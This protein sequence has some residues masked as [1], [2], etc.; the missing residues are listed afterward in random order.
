MHMHHGNRAETATLD[1]QAAAAAA[2]VDRL[3]DQYEELKRQAAEN[4]AE[5]SGWSNVFGLGIDLTS[6]TGIFY[7]PMDAATDA[8]VES[9]AE[10][11]AAAVHEGVV[12]SLAE[13]A[14]NDR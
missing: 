4:A 9:A 7:T 3:Q 10:G 1:A 2:E 11:A 5:P 8:A 13:A 14:V 6:L 12:S